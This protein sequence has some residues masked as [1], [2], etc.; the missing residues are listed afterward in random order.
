MEGKVTDLYNTTA[1]ALD[2]TVLEMPRE[3]SDGYCVTNSFRQLEAR[4]RLVHTR[5]LCQYRT[6][7]R[8]LVGQYRTSHREFLCQYR[9][10]HRVLV[11]Q[12]PAAEVL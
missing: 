5:R 3:S 9:T 1:D 6:S 4:E 8:E 11:G 7:H 12:Y 2:L 10:L